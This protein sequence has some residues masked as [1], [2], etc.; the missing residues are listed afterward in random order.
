MGLRH[1]LAFAVAATTF[2]IVAAADTLVIG[3]WNIQ[4]LHH[5]EGFSLRAFP[6]VTSVKRTETD[7][8]LLEK[9][10][11]LFGRDGTPAD[12]VA[13]QE[14]GTKTALEK[15]FPF[16]DYQTIMSPRW[17]DD[18]AAEGEGD[19]YTAIAVRNGSG[20]TIKDNSHI[21]E[22]SVLHSDGR[23]TRAA[24]GAILEVNGTEFAFLSVHLKSSC[25]DVYDIHVSSD[26]DCETLWSQMPFLAEWIEDKRAEGMPFIVAGD[27]NRRFR[28]LNFEGTVWKVLNG[29]DADDET[30]APVAVAHPISTPR[31]CSTRKGRTTQPIDWIV[32]DQTLEGAYVPGSFWERRWTSEDVDASQRGRGLSDHCPISIELDIVF[33]N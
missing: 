1:I 5:K 3:A 15:L 14:I 33:A 27:F 10:R 2:P 23:P 28:E 4:D 26:D 7:F 30:D 16:S 13:L 17:E 29:L 31:L 18:D 12:V 11:D 21:S 8:E 6:G 22:L 9:Y 25:P 24:T 19:V 32:L 20:V